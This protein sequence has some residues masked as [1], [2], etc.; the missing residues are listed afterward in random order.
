M[1]LR[2]E[3]YQNAD[4]CLRNYYVNAPYVYFIRKKYSDS[5]VQKNM[6]K[7]GYEI[8][9]LRRIQHQ[10]VIYCMHNYMY[11]FRVTSKMSRL[12]WI[13]NMETVQKSRK[14]NKKRFHKSLLYIWA[15]DIQFYESTANNFSV[16]DYKKHSFIMSF[17]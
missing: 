11:Q 13:V 12:I 16:N 10:N 3:I 14:T 5:Y 4:C 9:I 15:I 1:L 7:H 6:V 2:S 17:G 8:W